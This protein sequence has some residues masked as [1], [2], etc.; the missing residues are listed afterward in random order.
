MRTNRKLKWRNL[1]SCAR[2]IR[3]PCRSTRR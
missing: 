1:D 3:K 2:V